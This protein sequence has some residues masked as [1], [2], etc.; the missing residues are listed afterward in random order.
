MPEIIRR[1]DDQRAA[2]DIE[3]WGRLKGD[4]GTTEAH[5]QEVAN[6]MAPDLADYVTARTPGMKR[7]QYVYDASPIFFV[8]Q[9]AAAWHGR[10]TSPTVRWFNWV[11]D[12]ERLNR[13]PAVADWMRAATNAG[14]YLLSSETHAF[15]SQSHELYME[16]ALIGTACMFVLEDPVKGAKFSTRNMRE[17]CIAEGEDDKVDEVVRQ[18]NWTA[19]QAYQEWGDKAGALVLKAIDE[20]KGE[21]ATFDFLHTVRPRLTRDASRS[22]KLNKPFLSRICS[23]ADRCV[24]DE[25]GFNEFPVTAPRFSKNSLE[26][27]GRGRSM[28]ALPDVKMLNELTKLVVKS[29]QKVVDPPLQLP[30]NAFFAAIKTYPGSLNF[31]RAGTKDRIQPIETQGQ[32]QLGIEMIQ[33]LRQ[34]IERTFFGNQ[35]KMATDPVDPAGSGKGI[36]A[37]YVMQQ[38]DDN[39][40]LFSPTEARMRTEFVGPV[41]SRLFNILWRKSVAMRFGPGSPFP[42]PPQEIIGANLHVEYVSPIAVAQRSSEMLPIARVLQ[43]AQ[44]LQ[45]LNPQSGARAIDSDEILRLGAVVENA[46]ASILKT[47]AR[48]AQEDQQAA[49]AAQQQQQSAQLATV[50]GAAKDGGAALKHLAQ[51]HATVQP[52]QTPA[53]QAQA[54]AA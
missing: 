1:A 20:N 23:V 29:A 8:E 46:P 14:Y 6:Y 27:Y 26:I 30:D 53:P 17:V 25:G 49:Q 21:T 44:Q 33:A 50:A 18:W 41:L 15:A 28:T 39:N 36:T 11:T 9:L 47:P 35:L 42:Q 4:R 32:V 16:E 51:A 40:V 2:G 19:K 48:L 38:R 5:W 37:T 22:D 7:M 43:L 24:I 52:Q 13:I 54:Q 34:Q 31:Y 12:D 3:R 10:M 45:Q